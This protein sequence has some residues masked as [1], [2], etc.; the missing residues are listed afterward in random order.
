M[1]NLEK[2]NEIFCRC[3]SL[4]TDQLNDSL[5]YQGIPAWD[6]IGHMEMIAELEEAFEI[7][8]DPE[9]IIDFDSYDK[10]KELLAKYDV[11]DL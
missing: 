4:N 10:G 3:F 5:V 1:S 9:D 8:M 6:S 2:Y 7:S 11:V